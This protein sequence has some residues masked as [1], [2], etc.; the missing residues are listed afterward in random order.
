MGSINA[1][2]LHTSFPETWATICSTLLSTV[3]MKTCT[4]YTHSH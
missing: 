4:M 1:K 3:K 2:E